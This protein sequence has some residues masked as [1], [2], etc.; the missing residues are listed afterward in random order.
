MSN[1]E[2]CVHL[3]CIP[4]DP[5]LAVF[6]PLTLAD[7]RSEGLHKDFAEYLGL[8]EGEYTFRRFI[9]SEEASKNGLD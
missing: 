1:I 5:E 4:D 7:G 9:T 2:S 8:R 6:G 3:V